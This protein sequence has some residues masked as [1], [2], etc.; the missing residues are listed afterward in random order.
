MSRKQLEVASLIVLIVCHC[1]SMIVRASSVPLSSQTEVAESTGAGSGTRHAQNQYDLAQAISDAKGPGVTTIWLASD[2]TLTHSLPLVNGPLQLLS[3][4]SSARVTCSPSTPTFTALT[5][6][7]PSF[8][9]AGLTWADCGGVLNISSAS[10]VS[11]SHC[12]FEGS[13]YPTDV[14]VSSVPLQ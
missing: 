2:I 1:G 4:G 12:S 8:S 11:I 6:L 9:M 3:A 7:S 13:R 14:T 5:I 10:Q